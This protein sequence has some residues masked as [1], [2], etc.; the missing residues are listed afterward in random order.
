LT[1]K[2]ESQKKRTRI[3]AEFPFKKLTHM[4]LSLE[5][6]KGEWGDEDFT[7]KGTLE[8]YASPLHD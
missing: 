3:E 1:K 2:G 7:R 6:R 8:R 4:K 5:K